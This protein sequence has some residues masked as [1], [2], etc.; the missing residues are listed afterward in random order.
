MKRFINILIPII[1][2]LFV[3]ASMYNVIVNQEST[4]IIIS[5]VGTIV[6]GIINIIMAI[7]YTTKKDKK[8][9][10]LTGTL[11]KSIM[12]SGYIFI[13]FIATG[14]VAL[15]TI[16]I[17]FFSLLTA[18]PV[19]IFDYFVL[20][21]TSSYIIGYLIVDKKPTNIIHGILQFIFVLDVFDM[22]FICFFKEKK[23]RLLTIVIIIMSI[24]IPY[25]MYRYLI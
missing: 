18:I 7:I 9:L 17:G 8:S 16:F 25:L 5:I 22:L 19:V 23:H 15:L 6:F 21:V 11:L 3:Y 2:I 24:I 14:I 1:F 13:F 12:I 20:L 10:L 4:K